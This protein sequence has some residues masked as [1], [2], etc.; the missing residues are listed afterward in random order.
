[1][2]KVERS[3]ILYDWANS[4]YSIAITTAILPLYYKNIAT[5]VSTSLSTAY[6]GYANS[7]ATILVSVLAPILGTI[8]DYRGY[9]K[10]FFL[11]F[12]IV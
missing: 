1:M 4:A 8:A 10:K 11:F 6:W 9:K 7:I 12:F 3:W 5:G 2:K